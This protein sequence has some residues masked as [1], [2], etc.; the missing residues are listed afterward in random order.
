MTI[1]IG[2]TNINEE[3]VLNFRK[4]FVSDPNLLEILSAIGRLHKI[5]HGATHSQCMGLF[6]PSGSGKTRL[7]SYY[8]RTFL[9]S[10]KERTYTA[11]GI[12][13]ETLPILFVECPSRAT[14]KGM[15]ET[16][17]SALGDP[18]PSRG[19]QKEMTQRVVD[20]L[21]VR[22]VGLIVMD[23]FQ[24]LVGRTRGYDSAY[25]TA[26]WIK[27]LLNENICPILLVGTESAAEI[28]KINEQLRR[29]ALAVHRIEPYRV[30]NPAELGAFQTV[31]HGLEKAL[32]FDQPSYLDDEDL[33]RR[34]HIATDGLIGRVTA[35]L[36]RS[37]QLAIER[38]Q[39]C[40]SRATLSDVYRQTEGAVAATANPFADNFTP[41]SA[42][43][44]QLSDNSRRVRGQKRQGPGDDLK[45]L[46][47]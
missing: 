43:I 41:L 3:K 38:R 30:S 22:R 35:L 37:L 16:L 8:E 45:R 25:E 17:L 40:L 7:V 11:N 33:A 6:G 15:A 2:S 26:D 27:G 42:E 9:K 23:E 5:G 44:A 4:V 46:L 1:P 36:D 18:K 47:A 24:H 21:K 29:R 20:L 19:S 14:V 10:F 34:I 28:L 13:V 39:G 31:L 32:K 12:E